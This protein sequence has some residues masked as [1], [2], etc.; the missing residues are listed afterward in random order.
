[1]F[2]IFVSLKPSDL[3]KNLNM[4]LMQEISFYF[5]GKIVAL[6]IYF[7]RFVGCRLKVNCPHMGPGL[8]G[9]PSL[10]GVFLRDP[11]PYLQ[12][13]PRKTGKIPNG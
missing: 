7:S 9:G 10:H 1:M 3:L 4:I 12:E 6:C 13:F 2:L 8:I 5:I 11:S